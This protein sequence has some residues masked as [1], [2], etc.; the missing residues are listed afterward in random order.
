MLITRTQT[1]L[2]G[3]IV[4]PPHHINRAYKCAI[5]MPSGMTRGNYSLFHRAALGSFAGKE[6][7]YPQD[8]FRAAERSEFGKVLSSKCQNQKKKKKIQAVYLGL[9]YSQ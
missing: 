3:S 9:Y 2:L 4:L 8:T 1:S 6:T 7:S 5:V